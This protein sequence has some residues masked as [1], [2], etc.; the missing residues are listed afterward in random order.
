MLDPQT[1][2]AI[3]NIKRGT[4]HLDATFHELQQW[5]QS[6][7]AIPM[8]YG[9]SQPSPYPTPRNY[10]RLFVE[11]HAEYEKLKIYTDAFNYEFAH[12]EEIVQ[13]F[14]RIRTR[15]TLCAP[16]RKIYLQCYDLEKELQEHTLLQAFPKFKMHIQATYPLLNIANVDINVTKLCVFYKTN[17]DLMQYAANG[18]SKQLSLDWNE[19]IQATDEFGYCKNSTWAVHFDSHENV[20]KNYEGSY[21]FYFR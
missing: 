15:N 11:P 6:T 3:L 8:G 19:C 2:A 4:S 5:L 9:D 1:Q 16:K 13:Q 12:H 10:L 17:R 14:I 18:I 20:E 7:F 21:F